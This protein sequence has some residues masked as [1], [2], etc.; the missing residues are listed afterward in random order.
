MPPNSG[1]MDI[2]LQITRDLSEVVTKVE[3]L[4]S[5]VAETQREVQS[6]IKW[7]AWLTGGAFV[8]GSLAGVCATLLGV[9]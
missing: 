3:S 5:L 7:R 4:S 8:L 6:L 2:L 9:K 1:T